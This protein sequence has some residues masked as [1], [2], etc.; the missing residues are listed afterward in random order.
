MKKTEHLNRDK[1]GRTSGKARR[2]DEKRNSWR[3]R[4]NYPY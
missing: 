1:G 3:K 4:N 2:K